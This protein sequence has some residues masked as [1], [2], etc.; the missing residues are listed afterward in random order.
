MINGRLPYND[1][2]IRTLI[3]QTKTKPRFSTRIQV[4]AGMYKI[5]FPTENNCL[6]SSL[7]FGQVPSQYKKNLTSSES[8][9]GQF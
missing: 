9:V 6:T 2:D 4:T 5:Q 3:E 1:R 8:E 7:G